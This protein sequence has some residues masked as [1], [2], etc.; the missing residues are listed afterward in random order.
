MRA[1]NSALWVEL[2]PTSPY[3]DD[4]KLYQSHVLA[5][6]KIYVEMADRVSS[7]RNLTNVFFLT[8]NTSI[9]AAMG[10][11]F[12]KLQHILIPLPIVAVLFATLFALCL[13]WWWLLRSYRNLNSAKFKVIGQLERRLPASPFQTGE[14]RELGEG[15]DIKK[16]L[17]LTVLEQYVP[18]FFIGAYALVGWYVFY[19]VR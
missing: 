9:V 4:K 18:I 6:Y 2:D 11:A 15:L 1:K 19:G 10:F 7:R 13:V 3:S 17:P 16:Y 14:W 5:Q 8:L 12:E